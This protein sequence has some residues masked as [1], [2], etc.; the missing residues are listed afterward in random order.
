MKSWLLLSCYGSIVLIIIAVLADSLLDLSFG[1]MLWHSAVLLELLFILDSLIPTRFLWSLLLFLHVATF[2]NLL[3]LVVALLSVVRG[4]G[5]AFARACKEV[6]HVELILDLTDASH[7]LFQHLE[8]LCLELVGARVNRSWLEWSQ[9][10]SRWFRLL[11]QLTLDS[12]R[13]LFQPLLAQ[14]LLGYLRHTIIDRFVL[15]GLH[16]C[17]AP[18]LLHLCHL[19]D[20]RRSILLLFTLTDDGRLVYNPVNLGLALLSQL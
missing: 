15:L 4:V 17:L 5:W 9:K 3:D 14:I 6:L 20:R 13:I 7:D 10:D 12:F 19:G 2:L 18:F 16:L 11:L 8:R 1:L